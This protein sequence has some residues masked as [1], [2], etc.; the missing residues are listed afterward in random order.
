M[1]E[2]GTNRIVNNKLNPTRVSINQSISFI[3]SCS[4]KQDKQQA[5]RFVTQQTWTANEIHYY[6]QDNVAHPLGFQTR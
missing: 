5:M 1:M 2:W 6:Y 4:S 3:E